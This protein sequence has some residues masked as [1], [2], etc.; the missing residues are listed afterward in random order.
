M[1]RRE[2]HREANRLAAL[3]GLGSIVGDPDFQHVGGGGIVARYVAQ[4][5]RDLDRDVA[6]SDPRWE[7]SPDA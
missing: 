4:A 6:S 1:T 3:D 5:K 2:I 7:A